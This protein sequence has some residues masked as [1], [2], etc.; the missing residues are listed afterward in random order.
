MK[1]LRRIL[2]YSLGVG[3]GVLLVGALFSDRDLECSYFPNDRVLT[4]LH[5]KPVRG[6]DS[7]V[8]AGLGADSSL[9]QAF[10]TLG[11]VDF[12]DSRTRT[13]HAADVP[14][15]WIDVEFQ[16]RTWRGLWEVRRDSAWLVQL[17]GH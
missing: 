4:E 7:S 2:W 1:L 13:R 12:S 14:A 16:G 10:L 17:T 5:R 6:A 3:L 11:E 15:Y 9:L 8:W